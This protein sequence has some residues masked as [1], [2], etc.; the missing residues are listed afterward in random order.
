MFKATQKHRQKTPNLN[1]KTFRP[2]FFAAVFNANDCQDSPESFP[3]S[4]L[5][6]SLRYLFHENAIRDCEVWTGWQSEM[7]VVVQWPPAPNLPGT[8][9]NLV[10]GFN[11]FEKY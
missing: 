3:S 5:M 11:P 4:F 1:E 9:I 7:L 6:K 10:G 8:S 2:A